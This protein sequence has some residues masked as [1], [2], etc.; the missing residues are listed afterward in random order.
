MAF[1]N[2]IGN[3]ALSY[4]ANCIP[5]IRSF[6]SSFSGIEDHINKCF[7]AAK[8][9]FF[10]DKDFLPVRYTSFASLGRYLANLSKPDAEVEAFMAILEEEFRGDEL[11]SNLLLEK[12]IEELSA[13]LADYMDKTRRVSKDFKEVSSNLRSVNRNLRGRYHIERQEIRNLLQWICDEKDATDYLD[14]VAVVTGDAG[15]GKTVLLADLVDTLEQEGIPVVGLKSDFLFDSSETDIDKAVNIGGKTLLGALAESAAR[16]LTVLVIDQVD[17]LSL[18]LTTRRKPLAEVQRVIQTAAENP[19]IRVVFSC[20]EYDF[21]NDRTFERYETSFRCTVGR[22]TREQITNALTELEISATELSEEDYQFLETPLNLSLFCRFQGDTGF[23]KRKGEKSYH[24]LYA[25][26]WRYVLYEKAVETGIKTDRL[27]SYLTELSERMVSQQVLSFGIESMGTIWAKEQ[28]F[29]LSQGFLNHNADKTKIQFFHQTLFDYTVARLFIENNRS[30]D[31]AFVGIHQG[32]FVRGRLKRVIDYLRGVSEDDYIRAVRSILGIGGSSKA[33]RFHLKYLLVSLM[34]AYEHLMPREEEIIAKH[35][36]TDSDLARAFVRSVIGIEPAA[37][38]VKSIKKMGGYVNCPVFFAEKVFVL[39]PKIFLNDRSFFDDI[40]VDIE[41]SHL[42]G[43]RLEAFERVF[44]HFPIGSDEDVLTL[45]PIIEKHDPDPSKFPFEIFYKNAIKFCPQIVSRRI[46][47]HVSSVLEKWKSAGGLISDL[48]FGYDIE[49]I[50]E[51]ISKSN[52]QESL[53]LHLNIIAILLQSSLDGVEGELK[54]SSLFW[55]YNRQNSPYRFSDKV[56]DGL[57]S[58]VEKGVDESWEGVS[59]CLLSLS[60]TDIDIYHVIAIV[61]WLRAPAKYSEVISEYLLKNITKQ[62]HSTLLKY[63]QIELFRSVFMSLDKPS[64]IKLIETVMRISPDWEKEVFKGRQSTDYSDTVIGKTRA[65]FLNTIPKE[66]LK[67]NYPLAWKELQE[68]RRKG[69]Y[70]ENEAPNRMQVMTG[71]ST[72]TDVKFDKMKPSDYVKLAEKYSSDR[73]L[74]FS[75]PTRTG[76]AW[77]MR[78]R[79]KDNPHEFFNIYKE[80]LIKG[81]SD[82]FYVSSALESLLEGGINEDEMEEIYGLLISALGTDINKAQAEV[83]MDVCRSLAFYIKRKKTAPAALMDFVSLVA[84]NAD[85]SK[86]DSENN[87]DYNTGINRVRG[88]AVEHLIQCVYMESYRESIFAIMERIAGNASVAT[89]CAALFPMALLAEYDKERTMRLFLALTSDYNV[90]LLR[91]PAHNLNPLNYLVRYDFERL[92]PYFEHCVIMRETHK[93]NIIWLWLAALLDKPKA[94][95]LLFEMSD[96]SVEGRLMLV[97]C[98]ADYYRIDKQSIVEESLLRYLNYE[99]E[100]LGRSYDHQLD[101]LNKWPQER[102]DSYLDCFFKAPV[103]KYCKYQVY[104]YLKTKADSD[105]KRVLAWL[106][107]LYPHKKDTDLEQEKIMD[108]LL[109]AYNRILVFDKTDSALE[110]AMDLFDSFLKGGN[111]Y[112]I[113]K[114]IGDP[115][116]E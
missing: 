84:E 43:E 51:D 108:V 40:V 71:W 3:L 101:C 70:L 13:S 60:Q 35:V 100:E 89:R 79:A 42:S 9:K 107:T 28:D 11:C 67:G 44:N 75:T 32:L 78:E 102:V 96:A 105:A 55:F 94:K 88:C 111:V 97:R 45:K 23:G 62:E 92:I 113:S 109:A 46:I 12:K 110:K 5:D 26:F 104:N 86:D 81:K 59:D 115:R 93:A 87:I 65:Q 16:S 69:F 73:S 103:V 116:Y 17:A 36:L 21:Q 76:N 48:D 49:D 80:L 57:L 74:D 22:L 98:T 34:G 29:L 6:W 114:A 90:H 61:G 91:L 82:L 72:L 95:D 50:V 77:A 52:P 106:I 63:Y 68:I 4:I 24:A 37:L 27:I 66:Y 7:N 99:E 41:H 47:D 20:R 15:C 19:N 83:V 112:L 10:K 85:D 8:D 14:R 58:L 56:L 38:L 31:T 25:K 30:I 2:I 33:Y 64:Q 54:S 53:R 39:L 18:S 1:G